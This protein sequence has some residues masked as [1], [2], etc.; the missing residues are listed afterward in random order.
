MYEEILADLENVFKTISRIPVSDIG[1]DLMFS[2]K[3]QLKSIYAKLNTTN[4][5]E[6]EVI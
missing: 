4:A 1:V 2:A 6:K 5:D 3:E